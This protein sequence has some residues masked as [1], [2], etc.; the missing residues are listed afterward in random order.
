MNKRWAFLLAAS[1][2]AFGSLV[3][4]WQI[5]HYNDAQESN[6]SVFQS[7]HR[8]ERLAQITNI[9]ERGENNTV[10]KLGWYFNMVLPESARIFMTDMAGPTNFSKIVGPYSWIT[11]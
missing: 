10:P 5:R 8:G 2:V 6:A 11:Y 1:L 3:I 7:F 4:T 9:M